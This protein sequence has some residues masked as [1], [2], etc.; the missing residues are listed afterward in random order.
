MKYM[1]YILPFSIDIFLIITAIIG[2]FHYKKYKNTPLKY[3]IYFLW[4]GIF[5]EAMGIFVSIVLRQP[6]HII[7]NVYVLVRALFLLWLFGKYFKN[8]R[9]IKVTQFFRIFF[10]VGF[11]LNTIFFESIF[12]TQTL[13]FYIS[14]L[15]LIVTVILFFVEILNSNAILKIKNLLIFW[16]AAGVLLFE[17][18]FT[19]VYIANKY[20]NY[21][22]GLTYGYILVA[23]NI[24]SCTC[25]S[26]GFI[27][28]KKEIDY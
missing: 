12:A 20:I 19:P 14:S 15:S 27:N 2:S 24:I 21:S 3:F 17:L 16:I 9:N 23:L 5:T 26:L 22:Q 1:V 11:I 7:Y 10:I 18:G 4:Y 6:N 28:A 13:T 25:F 8:K